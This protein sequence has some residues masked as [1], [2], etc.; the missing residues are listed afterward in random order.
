MEKVRLIRDDLK[1]AQ[2]LQKSFV[3]NRKRDLEFMAG[4]LI[5]LKISSMKGVIMFGKKGKLNPL[6]AVLYEVLKRI[7]SVTYKLKLTS[8]LSPVHSV[9]HV[10]MLK[11]CI[12]DP[13]SILPQEG[14]GVY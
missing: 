4:D 13:V 1:M 11:K 14:L 5:Y 8:K 2:S 9:F 7:I 12:S 3:D 6:Y 10:S